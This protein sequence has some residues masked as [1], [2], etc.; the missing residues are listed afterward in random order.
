MVS[1]AKHFLVVL[2][3]SSRGG[4]H[5]MQSVHSKKKD[6]TPAHVVQKLFLHVYATV[7]KALT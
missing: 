7:D 1:L 4:P 3:S 5:K 2:W 6:R